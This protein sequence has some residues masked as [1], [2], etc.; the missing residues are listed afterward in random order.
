MHKED[1]VNS[2]LEKKCVSIL[3][4]PNSPSIGA[5]L[6]MFAL[7]QAIKDLGH[8]VEIL[9]Y[10]PPRVIHNLCKRGKKSLKGKIKNSLKMMI[11][12]VVPN[13]EP[14][15][16]RFENQLVK[17]PIIP[18]SST[19]ELKEISKKYDIIFVGSDQVWNEEVNGHDFNFYL[20][21]CDPKTIRAS[22]AASFGNENVPDNEKE[23]IVELLKEF[24]YISVREKRGQEIVEE[25]IGKKPKLVLDPTLLVDASVLR[26][27][28]KKSK[29]RNYVLFYTIKPSEK[30]YQQAKAFA[31][32]NKLKLLSISSRLDQ[33]FT[34]GFCSQYGVGPQEF[35]GLIDGASYI[36]TNSFH[37]AAI[38]VCFQK[39]F[40]VE[41]SSKTN[42]RLTNLVE[43]LHLTDNVISEDLLEKAP[44]KTDYT[45]AN[46]VLKELKDES[47]K[48]ILEALR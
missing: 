10:D 3:T 36:F 47:F 35:L 12:L 27:Q 39:N 5:S 40:Y 42:S 4:Y 30:L 16:K 9:N 22:Y 19:E 34:R 46:Q 43:L 31:K 32:K 23:R 41:Y 33:I 24:S 6:Q 8:D 45:M 29:K 11:K 13:A 15:F 25:L 38:S 18:T 48:Y 1:V 26:E 14:K 21:F 17:H 7:Y 28:A 44:I 20:E 37:G 2:T